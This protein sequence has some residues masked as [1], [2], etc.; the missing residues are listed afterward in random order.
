MVFYLRRVLA[1]V[2]IVAVGFLALISEDLNEW[3]HRPAAVGKDPTTSVA[4]DFDRTLSARRLLE[5]EANR[6]VAPRQQHGTAKR[7]NGEQQSDTGIGGDAKARPFDNSS[8]ETRHD[9]ASAEPDA[10]AVVAPTQD[11]VS[12]VEAPSD[13]G[14]ADA[15]AR[16]K[17]FEPVDQTATL[18]SPQDDARAANRRSTSEST[19]ASSRLEDNATN[20]ALRDSVADA[21]VSGAANAA[22]RSNNVAS[23]EER[24][25]KSSEHIPPDDGVKVKS[26]LEYTA[27]T[28]VPLGNWALVQDELPTHQPGDEANRE[29]PAG[30]ANYSDAK[31]PASNVLANTDL[32]ADGGAADAAARLGDVAAQEQ[33]P[34]DQHS[35]REMRADSHGVL[36]STADHP[37]AEQPPSDS[38]ANT[39]LSVGGST[40]H[41]AAPSNNVPTAAKPTDKQVELDD[42]IK[43]KSALQYT[44]PMGVP[45]EN[46]MQTGATANVDTALSSRQSMDNQIQGPRLTI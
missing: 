42:G 2:G 40:E 22:A 24:T 10:S 28:D 18:S 15:A 17:D 4:R 41:V 7:Q 27:P 8:A 36:A 39:D 3:L 33:L 12:N 45:L 11:H 32:S 44:A 34:N 6:V 16:L 5:G 31:K 13:G 46:S 43:V 30:T 26:A 37:Q 35:E 23:I 25:E 9:A 20:T 38:L 21:V 14:T 1:F 19:E 29:A